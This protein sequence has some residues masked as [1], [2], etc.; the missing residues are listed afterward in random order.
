MILAQWC[1]IIH[2]KQGGKRGRKVGKDGV[3]LLGV[4]PALFQA[5]L[6]P[7]WKSIPR[8]R[9]ARFEIYARSHPSFATYEFLG[10]AD[11]HRPVP[12][13]RRWKREHC[14]ESDG[15]VDRADMGWGCCYTEKMALWV[16]RG[17]VQ[18]KMGLHCVCVRFSILERWIWTFRDWFEIIIWVYVI[19]YFLCP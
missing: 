10:K 2:A 3:V 18:Q 19:N 13:R 12:L 4:P 15:V 1:S 16:N 14:A 7:T 11:T 8:L 5:E 6:M 17:I 9:G